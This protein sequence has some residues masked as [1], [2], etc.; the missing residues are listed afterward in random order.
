MF[1][2]AWDTRCDM[3]A[4]VEAIYEHGV[5]RLT[6]PI[7]LAEGTRVEVIVIPRE[8]ETTTQGSA[9]SGDGRAKRTP[10]EIAAEIAALAIES[11][12]DGFS[13]R[14]HDKVL[15]GDKGAR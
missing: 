14:D 12:D 2:R 1:P 8:P 9:A 13:G 6:R 10:A 4:P 15:Y 3:P 7:D 5:L 11:N